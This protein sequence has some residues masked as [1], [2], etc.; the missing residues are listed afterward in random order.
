MKKS[1]LAGIITGQVSGL[2]MALVVMVVFTLFL[3]HGPLYP[4][5]VIGSTVF[6]ESALQGFHFGALITGLLLHQLGP[7]LLWGLVFGFLGGKLNVKTTG[8]AVLLG[9]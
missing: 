7:S 4:V 6:G 3:G 5:Q 2:I 1:I 8:S 9:L